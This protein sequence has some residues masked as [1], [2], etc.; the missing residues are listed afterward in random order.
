MPAISYLD[1]LP[2]NSLDYG[3]YAAGSTISAIAPRLNGHSAALFSSNLHPPHIVG[4]DWHAATLIRQDRHWY[5]FSSTYDPR[6]AAAAPPPRISAEPGLSLIHHT[7]RMAQL[8]ASATYAPIRNA[9]GSAVKG[10]GLR[11]DQIWLTGSGN[12]QQQCLP[13]AAQCLYRVAGDQA[14]VGPQGPQP[15]GPY[16]W[17]PAV[18]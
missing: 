3:S 15:G 17:V 5:V 11:V 4:N 10:R 18:L 6:A 7:L 8:P 2:L 13:E 9:S 14:G 1:S 12:Q 16:H